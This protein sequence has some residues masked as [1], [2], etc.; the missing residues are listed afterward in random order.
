[1]D[2]REYQLQS[3]KEAL[4]TAYADVYTAAAAA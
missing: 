2:E 3:L 4:E 1:M